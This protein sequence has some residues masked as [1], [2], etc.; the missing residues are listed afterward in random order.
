MSTTE[1][2]PIPLDIQN[3][4]SAY[5]KD[6]PT[7]QPPP[8]AFN[9]LTHIPPKYTID[10]FLKPLSKSRDTANILSLKSQIKIP[11][12][13]QNTNA[14]GA[15]T[16]SQLLA[17]RKKERLPDLS[18]DLDKDGYVGGRDYVI[19]KRFDLDG[20]GKLNEIEKKN[21]YEA[22][23]NNIEDNYVWNVDNQGG[24]R[25][26]RLL[27]KRGKIIDADDFLP[28][29]ETYPKHPLSNIKPKFSTLSEMLES[30]KNQTKKEINDKMKKWEE[31]NPIK[32]I[33]EEQDLANL[34]R[35]HPKYTSI[36][37]IKDEMHKNA[38]IKC[39][40][41]PI[42][43]DIKDTK[44]DPTLEYVYNPKHKTQKDLIDE[45][46]RENLEE[47]KKLMNVNFK[48]EV[49]R[50]NEREDEIFAKMYS[51]EDRKTFT[52]IKEQRRKETNDYNIKTFSKQTIGVHGHELPKFSENEKM[53]EWWKLKDDY[54]EKP[55]Y[56]SWNEYTEKKKY[57]KPP[58]EDLLLNEHRDEEPNWVD[59]FKREYHPLPKVKK[60]DN[61]IIKVNN[62]NLW[63]DF[64]PNHPAVID[65]SEKKP[66]HIYK[67]STLVNQFAP[68][69]FK[70]GRF[71]DSINREKEVN[72]EQNDLNNQF[73]S[74]HQKF[75]MLDKKNTNEQINLE[76]EEV[77]VV[78]DSLFIKFSNKDKNKGNIPKNTMAKTKGF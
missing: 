24:K 34:T 22:L 1:K 64:D 27:Q 30:R 62:L 35:V 61:L 51:N 47:G 57:Y 32:F 66:Q 52:K 8:Q 16:Q 37:Q 28:V 15:L 11:W 36:S 23:A 6:Q 26:F 63:K 39:G 74:F 44:H 54:K 72:D 60:S 9:P 65:F 75:S 19:A 31:E 17:L 46:K 10:G 20:D 76:N 38:R 3:L 68:N 2:S 55:L 53:K 58:G 29:K 5:P 42:E 69:K 13:E 12:N 33:N 59:P 73:D 21:A 25:P 41:E 49:E 71:F 78:K 67:W 70:R 50:L 77:K 40:L 43:S 56:Q 14:S 45:I 18:Y 48:N 4:A 7:I